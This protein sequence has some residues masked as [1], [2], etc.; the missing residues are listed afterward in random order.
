M[1]L[2][3][4]LFFGMA[5]YY[6]PR[7]LLILLCRIRSKSMTLELRSL[8]SITL[9]VGN[10]EGITV[11]EIYKILITNSKFYKPILSEFFSVFRTDNQQ[12]YIFLYN[13]SPDRD[14]ERLITALRYSKD[15]GVS[16]AVSILADRMDSRKELRNIALETELEHKDMVCLLFFFGIIVAFVATIITP[17]IGSINLNNLTTM[18]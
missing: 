15:S 17:L 11:A 8:E 5:S 6:L 18:M 1:M 13:N 4:A 10:I 14:F 7:C 12:A 2:I 16:H 9:V 3:T